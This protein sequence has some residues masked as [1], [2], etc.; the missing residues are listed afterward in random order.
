MTTARGVRQASIFYLSSPSS[1]RPSAA[2]RD[3]HAILSTSTTS[4]LP[5]DLLRML[6]LCCQSPIRIYKATPIYVYRAIWSLVT[7][8]TSLRS[9]YVVASK[10]FVHTFY[11]CLINLPYNHAVTSTTRLSYYFNGILARG[12]ICVSTRSTLVE[13]VAYDATATRSNVCAARRRR[14]RRHHRAAA[15][16]SACAR[17]AG[18]ED[19][20]KPY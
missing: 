6:S 16:S 11:N 18:G 2:A 10:K 7:Q 13:R 4:S 8:L 14:R 20:R 9:T 5:V 12:R 19:L 15:G 3:R 17:R 1:H